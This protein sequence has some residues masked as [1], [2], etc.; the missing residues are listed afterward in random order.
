L[1]QQQ[2]QQ[3]QQH[4]SDVS[5]LRVKRN[6]STGDFFFPISI[7]VVKDVIESEKGAKAI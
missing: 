3:Q 4:R 5:P 2:Q 7:P 1:Q 6:F